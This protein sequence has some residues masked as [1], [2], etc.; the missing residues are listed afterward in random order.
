MP[1]EPWDPVERD[2]RYASCKRAG[3]FQRDVSQV[4]I[5]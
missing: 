4:K 1:G 5:L 2:R 3:P